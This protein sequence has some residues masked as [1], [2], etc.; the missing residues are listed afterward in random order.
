MFGAKYSQPHETAGQERNEPRWPPGKMEK[1]RGVKRHSVF[2][3]V[4]V[5]IGCSCVTVAKGKH[6][7][8]PV[9]APAIPPSV[10][11]IYVA[12]YGP[13]ATQVR[14]DLINIFKE[15]GVHSCFEPV[16]PEPKADASLEIGESTGQGFRNEVHIWAGATLVDKA[17][18]VLWS[19]TFEIYFNNVTFGRDTLGDGDLLGDLW[20]AAGCSNPGTRNSK[21]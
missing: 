13:A 14:T 19:G 20:K 11:K 15:H 9:E 2:Y 3:L 6:K 1:E 8:K 21:N 16:S 7:T 5:F 18:V 4:L 12:G 10:A 17:G